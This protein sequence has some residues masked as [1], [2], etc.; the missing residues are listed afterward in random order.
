[1]EIH[2]GILPE[3]AQEICGIPEGFEVMTG[4][5]I[6]YTANPETLPE[7]LRERDLAPRQRRPLKEFV[8]GVN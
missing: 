6:G 8:F 1:M 2:S 4:L 7:D 5:A 3:K